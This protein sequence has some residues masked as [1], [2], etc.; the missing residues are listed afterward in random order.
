MYEAHIKAQ[1]TKQ[2]T[3][4][5]H[6]SNFGR[7]PIPD[8]LSKDSAPWHPGYWR[9]RFLMFFT[10]HV[11]DGHLGQPAA[12]ISEIFHSLTYGGAIR[13]FEQIGLS[14]FRGEVV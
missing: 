12:T 6:F 9:R 11:Y 3:Y 1:G 13:N 14:G 10:I 4:D 2:S 5:N 7:S 8:N